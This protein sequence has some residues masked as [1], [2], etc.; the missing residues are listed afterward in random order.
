MDLGIFGK[1]IAAIVLAWCALV[2]IVA[3]IFAYGMFG[4]IGAIVMPILLILGT[5]GI[6][7]LFK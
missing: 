6:L 7:R 3:T 1:I 2:L 4:I 5:A